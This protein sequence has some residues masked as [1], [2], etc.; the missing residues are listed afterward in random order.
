MIPRVLRLVLAGALMCAPAGVRAQPAAPHEAPLTAD[1]PEATAAGATFIAPKAWRLARGPAA[2]VLSPPEGDAGIAIVDAGRAA[3]AGAAVESAWKAW[4]RPHPPMKLA[5]PLPG[6]QGWEEERAFDYETSPDEHRIVAALAFRKGGR[7]TVLIVDGGEATLERR[8]AAMNLVEHSLR[9]AGYVRETFAGRTPHR[10]DP[11][12]VQA[13]KD[14]VRTAMSELQVPGVGLALSDHGRIVFDGGLGVK[15]LGKAAPVDAHTLFMIASNTKG[16]TT[17]LLAR[18][19]DQGRLAWDEPVTKVYPPFRLGSADTT[20]RVL[21]RHL[22]CACTG[23]PRKDLDWIFDTAPSTPA[24]ATFDE[25]A[26]TRPT[27]GFGEVFQYNNL[28]AAA[29]GYI[30]GHLVYPSMEL[31]AAYDRAMRALVFAP[32]R[33]DD[34]TFDF[35]KALAGDHA[36]P[37]ADDIDGR[38]RGADMAFNDVVIPYRPAGGAWSSA[39]DMIAYVD[40]ELTEGLLPDGRRLV[41]AKNLLARRQP[42][43]PIGEDQAYGMG[44]EI[45]DSWGVPVIHHGGSMAGFKSDWAAIPE[46]DVGAVLLTNAD[47]G[48]FMLRAFRRRLLEIL[49]DGRPE[50]VGDVAALAAAHLA[51]L[52][53]ERVR[54]VAPADPALAARLARAYANPDLGHITVERDGANTV[55][56]FGAWKSAVASRR[57]D[58]GTVSFVTIDPAADG[59]T[60]VVGGTAG[61]RTLTIRDGQHRY[62]YTETP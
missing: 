25:L 13:V 57:N 17:L 5:T 61:G 56:D 44:L 16:M 54:L 30:G 21:I 10:L 43:V 47:E 31:G 51:E 62:L 9:P 2:N 59:F 42:N 6:R 8:A 50:A 1:R 24:L 19:V 20:R 4:G 35:A 15:T 55:F 11:A 22:V 27:S 45:D 14:F 23:L 36:S 40:D 32:L 7:W 39:H 60:F 58:D 41:S 3:D 29:A 48:G 38:M 53:K 28:M 33:M 46:A 52:R 49:Y 12:R 18:L 37:H 34:T 26:A